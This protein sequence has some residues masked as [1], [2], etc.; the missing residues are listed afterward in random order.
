MP[1]LPQLIAERFL[2]LLPSKGEFDADQVDQLRA[3]FADAK[4]L[5]ADDLVPVFQRPPGERELK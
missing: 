3:L 2:A 4:K 5:K 1:T